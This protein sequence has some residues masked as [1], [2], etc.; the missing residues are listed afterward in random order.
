M[1]LALF[2]FVSYYPVEFSGDFWWKTVFI[3]KQ[4]SDILLE[5]LRHVS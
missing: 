3:W 2:G 5:N 4:D 1:Y